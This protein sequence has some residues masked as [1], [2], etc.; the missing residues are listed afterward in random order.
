MPFQ[1]I[2]SD[3][4]LMETD[5]V[6][7]AANTSL[8]PGSGV[9]GAIYRAAGYEE[10]SSACRAIGRCET[11]SAVI[12]PGF[13]LKAPWVI[14][15]VGPIWQGGGNG[16]AEL[17]RSSYWSSLELAVEKGLR[18]LAFPLIS[19]GVFGYPRR[20]ALAVAECAIRDFLMLH[21][22]DVYLVLLKRD[23]VGVPG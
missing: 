4:V 16:E 18:S 22:L 10:M 9:C 11:G 6:V 20:E 17:L 23:E 8:R 14:H 19:A 21:D 2:Y 13:S 15:T 7:N 3:I 1:I 12:T 5:A